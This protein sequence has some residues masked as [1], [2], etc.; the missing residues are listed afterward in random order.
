MLIIPA[1]DIEEGVRLGG[2]SDTVV[3]LSS[4][5]CGELEGV[6]IEGLG[7]FIRE[8]IAVVHW[9]IRGR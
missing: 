4:E 3:P 7:R 9:G 1:N 8:W 6:D 5:V 2:F